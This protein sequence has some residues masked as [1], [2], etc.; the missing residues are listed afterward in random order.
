MAKPKHTPTPVSDADRARARVAS[1]AYR[2]LH[3]INQ[4]ELAVILRCHSQA[5]SDV[6]RAAKH[7]PGWLVLE[8]AGLDLTP[9]VQA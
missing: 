5:I 4:H 2:D 1:R 3:S 6:E 8:L 7:A 9:P